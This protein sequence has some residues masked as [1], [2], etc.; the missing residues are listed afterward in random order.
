M[1]SHKELWR[2]ITVLQDDVDKIEEMFAPCD[3]CSSYD[4]VG[5]LRKFRRHLSGGYYYLHPECE[6]E[7]HNLQVCPRCHGTG[8]VGKK[9]D[10]ES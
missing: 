9:P 10:G 6:R 7:E 1:F 5:K 3:N 4:F 8:E 2:S